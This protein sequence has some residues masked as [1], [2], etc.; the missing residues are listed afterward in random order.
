MTKAANL[1]DYYIGVC[2]LKTGDAK[3]AIESLN[4]FSTSED[5]TQSQ[6]Y[7]CLG[8]A[9]S[10]TNDMAK[11]IEYYNK[12]ANNVDNEMFTPF[13]LLK[14]AM[15]L[16]HEKKFADAKAAY[17]K[18]K[19]SYPMSQLGRQADGYIARCEAQM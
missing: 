3:K 12:A 2:Y 18:I 14:A 19:E 15:A 13:Y 4:S 6:A 10:E 8:D 17:E 11:A 7:S 5:L 16:E 9:Y 1:C